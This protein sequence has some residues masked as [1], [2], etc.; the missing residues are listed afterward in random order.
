QVI[1]NREKSKNELANVE[2]MDG[3]TY[4][5][6]RINNLVTDLL[7]FSKPKQAVR[8]K[9]NIRNVIR[10]S[11]DLAKDGIVRKEITVSIVDDNTPKFVFV[12]KGQAEQIFLNIITNAVEA[13]SEHGNL[14]ISAGHVSAEGIAW[15]ETIFDDDGAGIEEDQM[16]KIF[17]PFFTTKVK[18]TGLGLVVVAK[19]IEENNGK[20]S[21]ESKINQGTKINILLPEYRRDECEE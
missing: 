6:D 3:L 1:K 9:E 21:I 20:I 15:V 4:E 8:E 12:D 18:G 5:I 7:D 16:D 11:L 10:K 2:L 13:M 17:N 19:L 14:T